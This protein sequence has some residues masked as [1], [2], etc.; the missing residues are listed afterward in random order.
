MVNPN[1]RV[2][3]LKIEKDGFGC[4]DIHIIAEEGT[5]LDD[6]LEFYHDMKTNVDNMLRSRKE[7]NT[8]VNGDAKHT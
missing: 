4:Y 7:V 5:T 2:R 3:S 1:I 8:K 6:I